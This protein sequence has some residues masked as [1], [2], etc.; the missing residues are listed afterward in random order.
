MDLDYLKYLAAK[1]KFPLAVMEKDFMFTKTLK[2]VSESELREKLVFKGG[3]ALNKLY[4]G[5]YRL[6]EDLDFTAIHTDI[7]EILNFIEKIT[8]ELKT[9]VKDENETKFSYTGKLSFIGPLNHQNSFK[10]DISW[11]EKPLLP[12]VIKK[13]KSTYPEIPEF[14]IQTFQLKELVAEKFR[15][16]TQRGKPRDYFD[17]W[18]VCKKRPEILK[19]IRPL[20]MTKCENIGIEFKP[21]KIFENLDDVE[22]LWKQ[23]LIELLPEVVDFKV[24]ISE[25]KEQIKY[26]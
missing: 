21:K 10:V 11:R 13:V 22:K 2:I 23:D 4:F 19:D 8:G 16:L 20:V 24:V 7:S 18:F 6:S 14:K 17:V 1:N 25:L 5:Y 3:T 9:N 12:L 15:A 26:L